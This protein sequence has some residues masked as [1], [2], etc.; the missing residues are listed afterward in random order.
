MRIVGEYYHVYNRGAHKAQIF[1]DTSDYHRFISLLYV[2]NDTKRLLP[3][4][5]LKNI[6][7]A[8]SKECLVSIFAYCLMPNHFHLGLQE[9]CDDGIKKFLRKI[10]TA[11]A[12]YYNCKYKHSGTIFQGSAKSKYVNRDEY[13]RYLIQYIHLNP[14]GIEEPELMKSAKSE[15]LE[16]AIEYSKTYEFS[17]YRDY[18][19]ELRPQ[20]LILE[21]LPR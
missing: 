11:Y 9:N 3:D 16:Q 8:D 12:M 18:L 15:Y 10:C 5:C 21:V 1:H 4:W 13:L 19:G 14:F 20:N 17:S 6:W 2:A 7:Q